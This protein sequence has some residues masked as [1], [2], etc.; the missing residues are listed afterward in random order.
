M[1]VGH[2]EWG[3][4]WNEMSEEDILA[5]VKSDLR[6]LKVYVYQTD[7]WGITRA[8]YGKNISNSVPAVV[9]WLESGDG[10]AWCTK[11]Q[12]WVTPV[13]ERVKQKWGYSDLEKCP[14]GHILSSE[15]GGWWVER[16]REKAEIEDATRRHEEDRN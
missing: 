7:E 5:K 13:E 16:Q 6:W 14:N 12:E 8:T 11:C 3:N 15:I 2:P 1:K 10:K 9:A 4:G